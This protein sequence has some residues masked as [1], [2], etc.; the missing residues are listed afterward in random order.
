MT[1]ED[2]ELDLEQVIAS[3]C[4]VVAAGNDIGAIAITVNRQLTY[5]E[6]VRLRDRAAPCQVTIDQGSALDISCAA[7]RRYEAAALAD[8][9]VPPVASRSTC[10]RPDLRRLFLGY[11]PQFCRACPPAIPTAEPVPKTFVFRIPECLLRH[12]L[13]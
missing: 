7:L 2:G 10:Q 13:T 3:A 1:D 8:A 9:I 11:R 12:W 5:E 6:L 4:R